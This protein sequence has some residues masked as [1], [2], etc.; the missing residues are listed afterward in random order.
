MRRLGQVRVTVCWL[1]RPALLLECP[2][3]DLGGPETFVLPAL[4]QFASWGAYGASFD[5]Q[6]SSFA[7]LADEGD[8]QVN[9]GIQHEI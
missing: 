7:H 2:F 1:P 9:Y 6:E 4:P 3:T 5:S 8:C